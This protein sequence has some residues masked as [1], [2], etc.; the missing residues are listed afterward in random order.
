M[1]IGITGASG[2]LGQQIV[3]DALSRRHRVT[4]FS[5]RAGASASGCETARI[6][7]PELDLSGIE[8]VVHLAG[9]SI[10][11][12]W[13]QQKR[14]KILHSRIEGTRWIVDAI[15]RTENKPSILVGA[16]GAGIYGDRGEETLT[17]RSPVTS[18]GFLA[19]VAT[20]WET[21]GSKAEAA[22]VRYVPIRIA[23]VLGK[24]GGAIPLM[25][26]AFQMGLGGKLGSGKQW[27]SWIH[28]ADI[29]ALFMHVLETESILGPV[30]GASPNP[31]R[32][33][34]FTKIMGD[35]L[36]RP[37]FLAAPE[38]ALRMLPAN[39]ASLILDSQRIVPEKALESGFRFRF[40]DLRRALEDV[41]T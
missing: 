30:N 22:G 34:D 1:H 18:A 6:F 32:N 35:L 11:G 38:F 40:P 16:S 19:E 20:V 27:M 29:S 3:R 17:E 4:P 31:T 5:R 33:E 28:I 2:F 41:L 10:L 15:G 13:T 9:E 36:R 21:E 7:G 25:K 23:L 8:A 12:L 24:T 26:T 39:Q 37:T 14:S